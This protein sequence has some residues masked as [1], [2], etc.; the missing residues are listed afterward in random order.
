MVKHNEI[1]HDFKISNFRQQHQNGR[2]WNLQTLEY[3]R[4]KTDYQ[5]SAITATI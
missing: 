4:R 1:R 2:P 5:G 3:K